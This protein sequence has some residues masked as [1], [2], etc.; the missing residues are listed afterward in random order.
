[1]NQKKTLELLNSQRKDGKASLR[2]SRVLQMTPNIFCPSFAKDGCSFTML[3]DAR[4][5]DTWMML[6]I[7]WLYGLENS[8]STFLFTSLPMKILLVSSCEKQGELVLQPQFCLFMYFLNWFWPKEVIFH[9]WILWNWHIWLG[10]ASGDLGFFF[11]FNFLICVSIKTIPSAIYYRISSG[12]PVV[13]G[14]I[15][16]QSL[17]EHWRATSC[18][19]WQGLNKQ[20]SFLSLYMFSEHLILW[21]DC[22]NSHTLTCPSFAHPLHRF[23]WITW[24]DATGLLDVQMLWSVTDLI[25]PIGSLISCTRLS[26]GFSPVSKQ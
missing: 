12:P 19:T 14:S 8:L 6:S 7:T 17:T 9:R 10:P 11:F 20:W 4:F 23:G 18:F 13:Q 1:M 21:S 22:R 25:R 3:R 2:Q 15:I 24:Q 5:K 16:L 26:H